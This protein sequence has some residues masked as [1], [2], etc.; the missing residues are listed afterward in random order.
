MSPPVPAM[1][2]DALAEAAQ[3]ALASVLDRHVRPQGAVTGSTLID[4]LVECAGASGTAVPPARIVQARRADAT[5][6]ADVA[7]QLRVPL[8]PVQLDEGWWRGDS[9]PYLVTRED[10]VFA[11]AIPRPRGYELVADG[12]AQPLTQAEALTLRPTAW[13]V[14]PALPSGPV[15]IRAVLARSAGVGSRVELAV[16]GLVALLLAALGIAVPLLAGVVV[17]ELVPLDA[18]SRIVVIGIVLVLVAVAAF[19]L[20]SLQSLLIQR[21]TMRLD[22]RATAMVLLRI[23]QLPLSFFRRYSAGDLQQRLQGL[24]EVTGQIAGSVVALAS[25]LLLAMS[26]FVVMLIVAPSLAGLVLLLL[27]VMA[28]LA[29]LSVWAVVRARSSF[30]AASVAL[31][32]LTLSLLMGIAK[33]RVAGAEQRMLSRWVIAYADRQRAAN[34]AAIGGQRLGIVAA[35]TPTLVTFVVVVGSASG[36]TPLRLGQFTS[37]VA[38]AGQTSGA[39]ASMLV[40]IAVLLGLTPLL[41]AV[42][43]ILQEPLDQEVD[44]VDPGSLSGEVELAAVS[45]GYG[46][47]EPEVLHE[48]SLRVNPGE[49]VAVVGPSGSGKS[50]L[51]RLLIGLET[52][53]S[54]A[55]LYDGR[56]LDRLDAEAVRRQ[57]GVV[58]QSAQL[59][60]GTLLE[61]IVGTSTRTEEEAWEAARLAGIAGDIEAMPM[62]MR[63]FVSDGAS[64]FSGGQKQRI[65]LARALVR[66]PRIVVLDEATSTLDNRTQATVVESL[67]HLGATR[68][69][70]AHRVSTIRDADRIVVVDMGR[71]VE[72]GTYSQLMESDGL[73]ARMARRQLV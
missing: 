36:A 19:G 6:P 53:T 5:D 64:T 62:R 1:H 4:A 11:A 45:F 23:T 54:G 47:D 18:L 2:D 15:G 55:V 26:G 25:M 33:L 21:L 8:R 57:I 31:S 61:N 7:R 41:K 9:G 37:F 60:T 49:F 38:A 43:P 71:I 17:G 32:G 27:L 28:V 70:V 35:L 44:A 12:S 16:S 13:S 3:R 48:V 67:R 66:R 72:S 40:P 46:P 24:D 51:V 39:L 14:L 56:P 22:V 34:R 65:L 68:I 10:G 20:A 59:A 63:T 50:T 73:F 29:G 52:P 42:R 58:V 69:V 30:V